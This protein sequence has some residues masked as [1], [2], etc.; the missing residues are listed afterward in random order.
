MSEKKIA[1]NPVYGTK[2]RI[3]EQNHVPG[4]I[5]FSTDSGEIYLDT[6]TERVKVGSSN[7]GASLFY[8]EQATSEENPMPTVENHDD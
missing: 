4:Y 5:Y 6:E 3:D 2:E 1:F 7:A 8:S